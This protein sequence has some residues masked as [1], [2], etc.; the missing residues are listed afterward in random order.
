MVPKCGEKTFDIAI[1]GTSTLAKLP[2]PLRAIVKSTFALCRV[3]VWA[4]FAAML[5]MGSASAAYVCPIETSSGGI[6]A[7]AADCADYD[8]P[9]LCAAYF[10]GSAVNTLQVDPP[11]GGDPSRARSIAP[12][13][14]WH[15]AASLTVGRRDVP[16]GGSSVPIYLVTARLRH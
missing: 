15:G 7:H 2:S 3:I 9:A 14:P 1:V 8:Q 6:R 5:L 16:L 13:C 4:W 11:M 12:E 10:R